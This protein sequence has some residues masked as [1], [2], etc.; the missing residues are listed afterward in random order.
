VV[1]GKIYIGSAD[2]NFPQDISGRIY[3]YELQN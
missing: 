2:N 1:N 3:V